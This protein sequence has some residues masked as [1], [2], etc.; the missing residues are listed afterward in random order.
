MK[1]RIIN[2]IRQPH[3]VTFRA[4]DSS[5]YRCCGVCDYKVII[6]NEDGELIVSSVLD[7]DCLKD[8]D[9]DEAI[10]KEADDTQNQDWF[11]RFNRAVGK[12]D[13]DN[14]VNG[15]IEQSA[16]HAVDSFCDVL[17]RLRESD[18]IISN[19]GMEA[20]K[21]MKDELDKTIEAASKR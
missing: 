11:Y 14:F 18:C 21:K 8:F 13:I 10:R 1:E 9:L 6:E 20:L 17:A 4:Y 19:S 3:F 7:D 2:V 12:D 15:Q 16:D 5:N